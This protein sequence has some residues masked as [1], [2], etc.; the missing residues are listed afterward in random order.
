MRI[1]YKNHA[2]VLELSEGRTES[3]CFLKMVYSGLR[4]GPNKLIIWTLVLES[5]DQI[6]QNQELFWTYIGSLSSY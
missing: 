2:Y 3:L 1:R 6:F 4:I 5:F